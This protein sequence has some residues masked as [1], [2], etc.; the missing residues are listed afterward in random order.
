MILEFYRGHVLANDAPSVQEKR[1]LERGG[2]AETEG[3]ARGRCHRE[4]Q[5]GSGGGNEV[6]SEPG[7]AEV[8]KGEMEQGSHRGREAGRWKE[9][10]GEARN[11]KIV[12]VSDFEFGRGL[13]EWCAF[14]YGLQDEKS[15]K[16]NSNLVSC[17]PESGWHETSVRI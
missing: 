12:L 8:S 6:G 7:E 10:Q 5:T 1:E 17:Q 2:Q 4:R 13:E 9:G 14:V 16:L 3:G 11:R 15:T